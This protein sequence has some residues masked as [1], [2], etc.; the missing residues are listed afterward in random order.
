MRRGTLPLAA[1][2]TTPGKSPFLAPTYPP[3][4]QFAAPHVKAGHRSALTGQTF[5]SRCP[6]SNRNFRQLE[7]AVTSTKQTPDPSSNRN[8]RSTDF[9]RIREQSLPKTFIS[10]RYWIRLEIAVTHRKQSPV[11]RSNRYKITLK[12]THPSSN[13]P[14]QIVF[15]L[16]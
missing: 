1:G 15:G 10:N 2:R 11:V 6:I 5:C 4:T 8:F 7:N 13:S 16:N 14:S 12:R 9:H 3:F